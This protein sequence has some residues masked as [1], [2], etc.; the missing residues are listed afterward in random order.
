M[1]GGNMTRLCYGFND[2]E[3]AIFCNLKNIIMMGTEEVYQALDDSGNMI[4]TPA[5]MF[6]ICY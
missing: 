4:T 6:K 5:E 3:N 1:K 2:T